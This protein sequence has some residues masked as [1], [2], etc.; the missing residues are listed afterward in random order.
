MPKLVLGMLFSDDE[1]MG[2]ALD[3]LQKGLGAVSESHSYD[4]VFTDYYEKEMG[5]GLKKKFVV[6]GKDVG[7]EELASIK[8]F[9]NLVE[10]GMRKDGKRTVNID[11]GVLSKEG[12]VL[13]S[14]KEKGYKQKI[15]EGIFGHRVYS[16][17]P[18]G[19]ETF[20][21]TFPDFRQKDLMDW[22]FRMR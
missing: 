5:K 19:V 10:D 12:L 14:N 11:P 15:G 21:H 6:M 20:F 17:S 3:A 4:F 13:A 7:E 16:F 1:L 2:K 18:K 8:I 9:T 22:F